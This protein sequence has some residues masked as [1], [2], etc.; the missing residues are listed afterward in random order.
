MNIPAAG[1]YRAK[2]GG[3]IVVYEASGGALC[4]AVPCALQGDDWT[5]NG[6]H[7]ITLFD[8]EGQAKIKNIE[9]MKQVFGWDGLNPFGLMFQNPEETDESKLIPVDFSDREFDVVGEHEQYTPEG[10]DEER[11]VFKI[12]WLNPPGQGGAK[13][14]EPGD[15]NTIL[16][17]YG[18]QF[19][20]LSGGKSV[21][22]AKAKTAPTET[23]KAAAKASSPPAAKAKAAVAPPGRRAAAGQA[24]TATLDEA[25]EAFRKAHGD[26]EPEVQGDMWY[27]AIEAEYPGKNNSDLTPAQLGTLL[28]KAQA[29][30][31]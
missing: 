6:K 30:E 22:P 7:T 12:K 4:A 11:T 19:R 9:T 20:A 18:A 14:P 3:G 25:W 13:M 10:S 21:T 1:T 29:G 23:P 27:A 17:K 15:R 2:L 5:W 16:K 24:V 28:T 8:K 31:I 26:V